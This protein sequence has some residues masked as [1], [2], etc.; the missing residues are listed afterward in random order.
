MKNKRIAYFALLGAAVVLLL[1]FQ[2][3]LPF[4]NPS[5]G[6]NQ[7]EDVLNI[8]LESGEA[9][10]LHISDLPLYK[11]Y[12]DTQDDI[13]TEVERTQYELLPLSKT[14]SYLLLK[15]NCGNKQCSTLLVKVS[16]AEV[17]SIGLPDGIFGDYKL[18]PDRNKLLVRYG[19]NEGN[20]VVRH[21]IVATDLEKMEVIPLS[22][23]SA[24]KAYA[25]VPTWPIT[26]YEWTDDNHF[27]IWVADTG[28]TD[29]S[30][31]AKWFSAEVQKTKEIQIALA[32]L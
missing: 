10:K 24:T 16:G 2:P 31:L 6:A 28:S 26:D 17:A 1:L 4:S 14:D 5:V 9:L 29:F 19:Y 15:Y 7:A 11:A 18:S 13:A 12:L 30:A 8:K 3:H 23:A 22:S 21:I 20:Q 25:E 32:P 27:S